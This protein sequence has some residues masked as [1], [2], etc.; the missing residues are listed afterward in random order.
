MG[1]RRRSG[2]GCLLAV[3]L[4]AAGA[5]AFRAP[6]SRLAGRIELAP[7]SQ[8]SEALARRAEAR[9]RELA[10]PD[11]G[12]VRLS[13]AELQSL[14]TYT[15]GPLLAA[16]IED[17]T[18]EVRDSTLVLTARLRPEHLS[19]VAPP[20]VIRDILADTA[21]LA[22]ELVPEVREPGTGALRVIALQAGPIVVP[23]LAIPLLLPRLQIPGVRA[24][25]PRLLV[26][27]PP[28][29]TEVR[30][31][32]GGLEFRRGTTT[33]AASASNDAAVRAAARRRGRG[34][35]GATA[36]LHWS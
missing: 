28:H 26:P 20:E 18:V 24:A 11:G 1:R 10:D 35:R 13:E 23:A 33:G 9:I 21:R 4:V 16:G 6:L 15:W 19:G 22:V 12:T 17:P 14:L 30:T 36:G 5:W 34:N 29:I 2:I 7:A 27:L 25:G 3:A 32:P 8:P 31:G